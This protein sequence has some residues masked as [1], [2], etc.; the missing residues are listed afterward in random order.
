MRACDVFFFVLCVACGLLIAEAVVVW[1]LLV[2]RVF[3]GSVV[4]NCKC[5]GGTIIWR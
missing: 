3:A 1:L 2:A 4:V 5:V